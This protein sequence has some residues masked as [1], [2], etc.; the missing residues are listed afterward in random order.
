M[1]PF[2]MLF[3]VLAEFFICCHVYCFWQ[4]VLLVVLSVEVKKV[5]KFGCI[6]LPV[7]WCE[8]ELKDT[9]YVVVLKRKGEL[10]IFPLKRVDLREFFDSLD[11]GVDAIGDWREFE[12]KL[13]EKMRG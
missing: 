10:R 8:R 4:N 11:F 7:D 2:L 13:V 6:V 1:L 3:M 5:D 12:R 9:N